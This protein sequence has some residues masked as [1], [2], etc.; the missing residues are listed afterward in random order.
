MHNSTL[1]EELNDAEV[2]TLASIIEVREYRAG[3]FLA[4]QGDNSD[5]GEL[6]DSLIMLGSG[7][8][9]V[10]CNTGGATATWNLRNP[11][12]LITVVGFAFTICVLARTDVA[13]R[14][15]NRGRFEALLNSQPLDCV[16]RDARHHSSRSLRRARLQHARDGT[17]QLP[18]IRA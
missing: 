12:E 2:E 4:W 17:C 9:E 16:S 15:L 5:R 14:V 3:N 8:V 10:T 7:E 11:G 6:R 18:V 1:V 13:M